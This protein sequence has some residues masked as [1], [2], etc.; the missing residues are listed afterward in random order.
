MEGEIVPLL[1]HPKIFT[2]P[3]TEITD[4]FDLGSRVTEISQGEAINIE[5]Y[6]IIYCRH[7]VELSLT[8]LSDACWEY[9][10]TIK[11]N[12]HDE[13]VMHHFCELGGYKDL[14]D[15][16]NERWIA[17]LKKAAELRRLEESKR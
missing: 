16:L 8:R 12:H 17:A 7:I 14:F 1:G 13:E 2:K 4:N 9:N 11:R 3:F 6:T 5:V 15:K 10:E